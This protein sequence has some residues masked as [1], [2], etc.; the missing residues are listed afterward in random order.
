MENQN[1]ENY[2][3][4]MQS[5]QKKYIDETENLKEKYIQ[6]IIKLK[7]QNK[8]YGCTSKQEITG[9]YQSV[10]L[11]LYTSYENNKLL[12]ELILKIDNIIK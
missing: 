1:Q 5:L 6:E 4:K 12:K 8:W 11:N 10:E 3:N 9:M 2:I 7:E